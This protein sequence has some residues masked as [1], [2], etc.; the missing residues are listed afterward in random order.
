MNEILLNN[1][2]F[3]QFFPVNKMFNNDIHNS[4]LTGSTST[5]WTI[6]D[7]T[8]SAYIVLPPTVVSNYMISTTPGGNRYYPSAFFYP[9]QSS[10]NEVKEGYIY[11][12]P[13]QSIKFYNIYGTLI[14]IRAKYWGDYNGIGYRIARTLIISNGKETRT[15]TRGSNYMYSFSPIDIDG[16]MDIK[17]TNVTSGADGYVI[18]Y[19]MEFSFIF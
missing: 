4:I 1:F 12:A 3:N 9:I 16:F 2:S 14:Q 7:K 15:T 11:F 17:F 19:N 13:N 8:S 10:R 18:L 6:T 5:G